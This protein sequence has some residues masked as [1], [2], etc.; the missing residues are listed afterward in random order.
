MQKYSHLLHSD[1][2]I[3]YNKLLDRSVKLYLIHT[4]TVRR[5]RNTRVTWYSCTFLSSGKTRS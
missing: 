1:F 5:A 3:W 4:H 2:Q